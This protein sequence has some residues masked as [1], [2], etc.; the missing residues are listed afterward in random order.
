MQHASASFVKFGSRI[1]QSLKQKAWRESFLT[2]V[3]AVFGTILLK[4]FV[5]VSLWSSG[6]EQHEINDLCCPGLGPGAPFQSLIDFK[7]S[8]MELELHGSH[9]FCC[10]GLGLS[11]PSRVSYM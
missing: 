9:G 10:P 4:H 5:P 7:I 6:L 2:Q 11:A 1:P 3:S 8:E